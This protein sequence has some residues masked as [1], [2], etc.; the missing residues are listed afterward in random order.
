M[1]RLI[2]FPQTG[3]PKYPEGSVSSSGNYVVRGGQWVSLMDQDEQAAPGQLPNAT[4][5]DVT[6]ITGRA[7]QLGIPVSPEERAVSDVAQMPPWR[8][9]LG[10]T[11]ISGLKGVV[12]DWLHTPGMNKVEELI[13]AGEQQATGT[14]FSEASTLIPRGIASLPTWATGQAAATGILGKVPILGK[15]VGAAQELP[16]LF[17]RGAPWAQKAKGALARAGAG[18]T[19]FPGMDI[20]V[21]GQLPDPSTVGFGAGAGALLGP[22]A[23]RLGAGQRGVHEPSAM[24]PFAP[25]EYENVKGGMEEVYSKLLDTTGIGLENTAWEAG[26]VREPMSTLHILSSKGAKGFESQLAAHKQLAAAKPAYER[27]LAWRAA[28]EP[29]RIR[30]PK[31]VDATTEL[32]KPQLWSPS[33]V[34]DIVKLLQTVKSLGK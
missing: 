24:E 9:R 18:A 20:A 11:A 29:L 10:I 17:K 14:P 5:Q 15:V 23:F 32:N 12:P 16:G 6:S 4:V 22:G 13:Q 31:R 2:P 33:Q 19:V 25:A 1:P 27:E 3:T 30:G 28:Q 26:P 8:R 34:L 21:K 7:R